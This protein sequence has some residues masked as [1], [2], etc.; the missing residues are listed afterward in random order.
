MPYD[1]SVSREATDRPE[2]DEWDDE[3]PEQNY[4]GLDPAFTSWEEVNGM[5]FNKNY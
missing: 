4:D 1:R 3:E 2:W 5:F